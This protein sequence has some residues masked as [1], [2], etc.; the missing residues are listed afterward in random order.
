MSNRELTR[1]EAADAIERRGAE[2]Y[3]AFLRPYLR[4]DMVIL[5]CGCGE[6][7]I[8]L[9]L[10]QALRD[11]RIVGVDL[12]KGSLAIAG[13]YAVAME[14]GNLAFVAGDGRQLPFRDASFD[15]VLCHSVLETVA[16]PAKLVEEL[17]RVT[18]PGGLVGAASV[19]Y[20]GIIL[21]G[22][23]AEKPQR[24]YDIR[25]QLWR[26][27]GI[28]EPNMGRRLRGL[29]QAAQFDRVEAF[30]DYISYGTPD[31]VRAFA[32]DRAAECRDRAWQALVARHAIASV[33][34]LLGLAD[35]WEAWSDDPGAFFAFAWCR[36]VAR[37]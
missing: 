5:D 31:R 27:A 17:R 25:R 26:A 1:H 19:D 20:G 4:P 12:D 18:K 8:A 7:A 6:A 28:A 24:F 21:G 16:D 13:G 10:A 29:F 3:A 11:G 2:V 23:C 36:V 33:D 30:A 22:G 37:R 14:C 15:A 9:G 35:A 32:L 34:E